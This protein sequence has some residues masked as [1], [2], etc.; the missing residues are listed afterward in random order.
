MNGGL[1]SLI[2]KLHFEENLKS[3]TSF[4][5]T[6]KTNDLGLFAMHHSISSILSQNLFAMRCGVFPMCV[7][8][9]QIT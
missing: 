7:C 1:T 9:W 4:S 8:P 2:D 5:A 6:A 3:F